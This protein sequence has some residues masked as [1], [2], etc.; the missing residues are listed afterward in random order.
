MADPTIQS[1]YAGTPAVQ[2]I[3]SNILSPK[4]LSDTSSAV[5][6]FVNQRFSA[7]LQAFL[8]AYVNQSQS[9]YSVYNV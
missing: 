3:P 6:C 2:Y 1:S 5:E 8:V 4:A 9:N 7:Q